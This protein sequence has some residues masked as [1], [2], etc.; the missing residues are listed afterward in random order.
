MAA[1][2][3]TKIIGLGNPILGD[4]GVGWKVADEMERLLAE[5]SNKFKNQNIQVEKA[6]LGGLSLMELLIDTDYAILIDAIETHQYPVGTVRRLKLE[7]IPDLTSGHTASTHDTSLANA[8]QVG[9]I[10]GAHLPE[11]I[12]IVSIEAHNLFEFSE[13]LS[14]PVEKAIPTACQYV[15]QYLEEMEKLT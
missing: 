13:Q 5:D 9:R 7:D 6:S 8:V 15:W 12:H 11:I 10:M 3:H 4:D 14:T 1:K 2:I